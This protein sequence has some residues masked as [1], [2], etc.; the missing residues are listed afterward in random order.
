MKLQTALCRS[1]Q[2]GNVLFLILIAVALFAALSYVVTLSLRAGGSGKETEA[3]MIQSSQITQYPVS[4]GASVQRMIMNGTDLLQIEFNPPE[5][6]DDLSDEKLGVFHPTGG[7]ATYSKS[8]PDTMDG[9]LPGTWYFNAEFEI[10]SVGSSA[11]SDF[12]GNDLVAFLPGIKSAVCEELNERFGI[13]GDIDAPAGAGTDATTMMDDNYAI[14]ATET[15][16]GGADSAGLSGQSF[17]CFTSNGQHIYYH[18]L[19]AR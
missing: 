1:S 9:A 5:N 15:I 2:N 7:G 13:T 8:G 4:V 19:M 11:A 18:V 10:D 16:L 14:P 17:G 12:E 3:W 6:F